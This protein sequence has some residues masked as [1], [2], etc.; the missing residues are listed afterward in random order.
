MR[1]VLYGCPACH[2][3]WWVR[4]GKEFNSGHDCPEGYPSWGIRL[5]EVESIGDRDPGPERVA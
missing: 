2:A 5:D 1:F 4:D 3:R